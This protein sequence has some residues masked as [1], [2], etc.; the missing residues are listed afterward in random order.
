MRRAAACALVA[1]LFSA[2][3][4]ADMAAVDTDG[5]GLASF[6]ELAAVYS[7]LSED[8]FGDLDTNDDGLLDTAEMT[9]G[10]EAGTL[11]EEG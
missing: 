11:V 10:V 6:E 8:A 9:A 5:D 7:G 1:A 2:P 3:A 4:F